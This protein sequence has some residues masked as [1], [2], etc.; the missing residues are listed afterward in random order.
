MGYTDHD[1][2]S[3]IRSLVTR[4]ASSH[5]DLFGRRA[6][7]RELGVFRCASFLKEVEIQASAAGIRENPVFLLW[8]IW[9]FARPF[10][11]ASDIVRIASLAVLPSGLFE[12]TPSP[13]S[14]A[15]RDLALGF[16]RRGQSEAQRSEVLR[17]VYDKRHGVHLAYESETGHR[18]RILRFDSTED[19]ISWINGAS[20]IFENRRETM[21]ARRYYEAQDL[22]IQGVVSPRIEQAAYTRF[23]LDRAALQGE[24]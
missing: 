3:V 15:M 9:P 18:F 11:L 24:R 23:A 14:R 12:T 1:G 10:A 22:R 16:Y 17:E 19:V 7:S 20:P 2:E 5:P 8:R 6:A 4:Y 21:A 13:I